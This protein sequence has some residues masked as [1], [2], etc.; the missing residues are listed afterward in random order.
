MS[1][2]IYYNDNF[3]SLDSFLLSESIKP[4]MIEYG[5]NEKFNN[6]KIF[7]INSV[8]GGII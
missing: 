2:V 6:S 7:R 3:M 8:I 1:A 5:T 4:K